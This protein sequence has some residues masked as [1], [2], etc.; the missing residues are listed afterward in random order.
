MKSAET[1][2]DVLPSDARVLRDNRGDYY[3]I[4]MVEGDVREQDDAS[5]SAKLES[6][7]SLDPGVR[8]F[9]TAYSADGEVVEWGTGDVCRFYRLSNAH[10]KLSMRW[11]G[12]DGGSINHRKRYRLKRAGARI[13]RKLSN[14]VDEVHRKLAKWLCD[15]FRVILIPKF[16]TQQMVSRSSLGP[17]TKKAMLTWKHYQFRTRLIAKAREYEWAKVVVTTEEYTSKTCGWCGNIQHNLGGKKNYLCRSC[18]FEADRD[19][20]GARNILIRHLTKEHRGV[21]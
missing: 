20:N 14:L 7:V 6:V 18:G 2:P 21:Q 5:P 10:D 12:K 15:N 11:S 13:R 16:E 9:M 1:L 17:M 3:L 4:M 8:T 19:H